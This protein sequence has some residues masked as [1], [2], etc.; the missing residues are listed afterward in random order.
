MLTLCSIYCI[1][2]IFITELLSLKKNVANLQNLRV[3][4]ELKIMSTLYA[5]TLHLCRV[6]FLFEF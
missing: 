5:S 3:C 2:V 4:L 1:L 6:I